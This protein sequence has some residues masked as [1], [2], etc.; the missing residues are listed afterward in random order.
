MFEKLHLNL[1]NPVKKHSEFCL[2]L[3]ELSAYAGCSRVPVSL[4]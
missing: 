3:D 2:K 4:G 1:V